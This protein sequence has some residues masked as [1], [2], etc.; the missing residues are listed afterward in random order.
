MV[1][2]GGA[3]AA[4]ERLVEALAEDEETE[5]VAVDDDDAENK[6]DV[7]ENAEIEAEEAAADCMYAKSNSSS[8][9]GTGN[10]IS[11]L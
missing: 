2:G 4:V 9:R 10:T 6:L 3:N 1:V 5:V 8:L 11:V 7:D